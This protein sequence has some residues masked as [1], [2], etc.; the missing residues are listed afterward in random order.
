[1]RGLCAVVL[2]WAVRTGGVAGSAPAQA[3]GAAASGAQAVSAGPTR[4]ALMRPAQPLP[5]GEAVATA[6]AA[7]GLAAQMR[8][9]LPMVKDLSLL[10]TRT[11]AGM[12]VLST[13]ARPYTGDREPLP[14]GLEG[15]PWDTGCGSR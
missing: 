14:V 10:R 7:P 4:V 8:A 9:F 13:A 1:M 15:L 3:G 5:R 2:A 12:P 6:T 11:V